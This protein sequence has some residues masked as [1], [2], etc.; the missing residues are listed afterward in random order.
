MVCVDFESHTPIPRRYCFHSVST[1]VPLVSREV[2]ECLMFPWWSH[3]LLTCVAR[4]SAYHVDIEQRHPRGDL[5]APRYRI[6]RCGAAHRWLVH[7][8]NGEH[9][10]PLHQLV[11]L[12][13]V[14]LDVIDLFPLPC[15]TWPINESYMSAGRPPP[16]TRYLSVSIA[17]VADLGERERRAL[18][19]WVLSVLVLT[20]VLVAPSTR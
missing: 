11:L 15:S 19:A 16:L 6:G 4:I 13:C 8:A 2:F 7:V 3:D 9:L 18:P 1:D 5:H 14:P 17:H 20:P 10:R 12:H